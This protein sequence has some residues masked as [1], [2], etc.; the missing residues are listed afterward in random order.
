MWALPECTLNYL[1]G[2]FGLGAGVVVITGGLSVIKDLKH[3]FK[4][5]QM[6]N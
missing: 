3:K 1:H 5:K 4:S 2:S 6:M